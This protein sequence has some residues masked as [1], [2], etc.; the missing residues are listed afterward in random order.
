VNLRYADLRFLLPDAPR[1]VTLLD[2]TRAVAE[3]WQ[4]A[5]V[6]VIE[7][8]ASTLP[9]VVVAPASWLEEAILKQS[10]M[11]VLYGRASR[12]RLAAAGYQAAHLLALPSPCGPRLVVPLSSRPAVAGA[13]SPVGRGRFSASTARRALGRLILRFGWAPGRITVTVAA[14]D[15]PRPWLIHHVARAAE[16]RRL[17]DWY[18]WLG[19]GDPLQR[20]VLHVPT[21]MGGW[22]LK[23]SRVPGNA[24]PFRNEERASRASARL[25]PPLAEHVPRMIA[26]GSDD[27]LPFV[28]ETRFAGRTLTE[29]LQ[30]NWSVERRL[31]YVERVAH[32][33]R[34]VATAT[35]APP[36]NLAGERERLTRLVALPWLDV[37]AVSA[38][39]SKVEGVPGV[40]VH[41]DPGSWN[42]VVDRRGHFGLV[43]WE[44][45]RDVGLPLWDL[46]YFL[47]DA[48]TLI[49]LRRFRDRTTA[50]LKLFRG[51][52]DYS[53][54]LF[55]QVRQAVTDLGLDAHAVGPLVSLGWL[56]HAQSPHL[57]R[58]RL[59][60][61]GAEQDTDRGVL[62]LIAKPWLGDPTLGFGWRAWQ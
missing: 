55:A 28:V 46:T 42:V 10:A 43:D 29:V 38:A 20:A 51:Q 24:A 36:A 2:A 11:L 1:S 39:M 21:A 15:A 33:L 9:E 27:K 19:D 45:S 62:S 61:A 31:R 14:R 48:L 16:L 8:Q 60:T 35:K 26:H 5:G 52:S 41:N 30:S 47:A 49:E 13:L 50:I 56:H 6:A 34:D 53:E 40:L 22:A 37:G 23:F 59:R 57:R 25:P 58:E 12:R 3:A 44:S 54:L 4:A 17:D 32:W 7:P 18:L